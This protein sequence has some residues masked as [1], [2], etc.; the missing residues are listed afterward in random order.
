MMSKY[1][2]AALLAVGFHTTEVSAADNNRDTRTHVE[3]NFSGNGLGPFTSGA[4]EGNYIRRSNN[5][6]KVYWAQENYRNTGG[7]RRSEI[8][9]T[10][11]EH[12]LTVGDYWVGFKLNVPRSFP[13]VGG[14]IVHQ[15]FQNGNG[16]SGWFMVMVLQDNNIIMSHRDARHNSR[17]RDTVLVRNY[18]RDRDYNF[19]TRV[20]PDR[21]VMQCWVNGNLTMDLRNYTV[22][23]ERDQGRGCKWGIYAPDIDNHIEGEERVLYFDNIAHYISGR[24]SGYNVVDP[25]R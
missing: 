11:R 5:R 6:M 1:L 22:G 10:R 12:D 9:V 15:N 23:F 13:S 20:R 2:F 4:R 24:N 14:T 19:I 3:H 17:I 8:T 7:T 21:R 16:T 18:R 25:T